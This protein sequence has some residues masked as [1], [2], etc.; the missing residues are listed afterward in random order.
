M[1]DSEAKVDSVDFVGVGRCL[2]G[3]EID[4]NDCHS[5]RQVICCN[6]EELFSIGVWALMRTGTIYRGTARGG[7]MGLC[8]CMLWVALCHQSQLVKDYE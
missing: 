4:I 8:K 3:F 1:V 6:H 5:E 2:K 7:R